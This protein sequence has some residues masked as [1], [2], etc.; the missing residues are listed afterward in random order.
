M[1]RAAATALTALGNSNS[2]PSPV[3]LISLPPRSSA[4]GVATSETACLM[5]ARAAASSVSI[6]VEEPTASMAI[7]AARRRTDIEETSCIHLRPQHHS[8]RDGLRYRRPHLT[9]G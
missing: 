2:A 1:A 9:S 5:D 4:A 3:V 8:R 7:M 6:A